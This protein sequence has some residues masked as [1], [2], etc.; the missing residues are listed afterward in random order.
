MMRSRRPWWALLTAATLVLASMLAPTE[1]AAYRVVGLEPGGAAKG[2]PDDPSDA[3]MTL[4]KSASGR[5]AIQFLLVI[6]PLPG[7]VFTVPVRAL[8]SRI[9]SFART[10]TR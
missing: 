2:D 5:S 1:G 9:I 6:Q 8:P 7:I 10:R 4:S 3:P